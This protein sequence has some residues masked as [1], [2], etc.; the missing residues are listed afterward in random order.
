MALGQPI[1]SYA[2]YFYLFIMMHTGTLYEKRSIGAHRA[3][4]LYIFEKAAYDKALK[5]LF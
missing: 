4:H 2:F 5:G 1:N 3:P